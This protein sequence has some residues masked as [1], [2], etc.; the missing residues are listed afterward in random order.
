[1]IKINEIA[2]EGLFPITWCEHFKLKKLGIYERMRYKNVLDV[3]CGTGFF[4]QMISKFS[5][6]VIGIDISEDNI[7]YANKNNMNGK[8]KFIAMDAERM[9][10][11]SNFDIVFCSEVYEHF[12][13]K[14]GTLEKMNKLIKED[15]CII[16]VL[17]TRPHKFPFLYK[18]FEYFNKKYAFNDPE[19]HKGEFFAN[20]EEIKRFASIKKLSI[21]EYDFRSP[22]ILIIDIVMV[23][24]DRIFNRKRK[25]GSFTECLNVPS[26]LKKII[27][28]IAKLLAFFDDF[29][30]FIDTTGMILILKK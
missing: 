19:I 2:I 1:M 11:K 17:T 28:Q 18:P 16:L 21:E 7:N 10:F 12:F 22:F 6:N 15:G 13:D 26:S 14:I 5:K 25:C 3:G 9:N 29:F 24:I 20:V 8:I 23:F 30:E 4:S 27:V